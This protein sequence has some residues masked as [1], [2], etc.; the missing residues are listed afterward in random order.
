MPKV[1]NRE[2]LAEL[3]MNSQK[4][5]ENCKIKRKYEL[6]YKSNVLKLMRNSVSFK[7]YKL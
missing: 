6:I 3:I 1:N 7:F 2:K 4:V 5:A